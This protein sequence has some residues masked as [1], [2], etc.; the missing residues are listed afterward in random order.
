[1]THRVD[2]H[3]H[4]WSLRRRDQPWLAADSPLRRDFGISELREAIDGTG[5]ER[6][7]LVQVLNRADETA[8]LLSLARGEP[9]V[10]GVVAWADLTS[11][12]LADD[13]AELAMQGP[14]VGVRH[15]LQAEPDP[16]EWLLRHDVGR[17]LD[18]LATI[19]LPFDLMLRPPQLTPAAELV[20]RHPNM[21]FVL[22]H[23]GKPPTDTS[24]LSA[25]RAGMARLAGEPNV[26][27][28][29]S[30]LVNETGGAARAVT[31]FAPV[32]DTVFECFGAGRIMF[33][34]DWPVC[35]QAA[36]YRDVLAIAES[37]LGECSPD[38]RHTVWAGTAERVYSLAAPAAC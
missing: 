24:D 13:L 38:E 34:S 2:A 19:G 32:T 28:K 27:C 30:G 14:L 29:L 3:H 6:T 21:N 12:R 8:E 10:A 9:L 35:L 20:R 36:G 22:D 23:C 37:A 33:G 15:Q 7:V 17:G 31:D 11:P 5:I 1:V 18:A 25:W 26:S 16:E 4:L